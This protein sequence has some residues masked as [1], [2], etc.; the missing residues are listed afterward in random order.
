MLLCGREP[1]KGLDLL[2]RTGLLGLWL[3]ELL[4]MQGCVQNHHHAYPVWEHSLEVV[5]RAD[6]DPADRWA[7]LLHDGGKPGTRTQDA[8]GV[9]HFHGHEAVSERLAEAILTRLRAS[10]ALTATVVALVRHHGTH[11]GPGWGDPACRRFLKRL[12]EDGLALERW[13]AFRLADQS[14]KGFG[15]ERCDADHVATMA[16][17]EALAQVRP[18]L[19][20]KALALDGRALMALARRKG[21][22]WLGALQAHLM[23]QVLDEPALNQADALAGLV[24]IWLKTDEGA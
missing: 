24:R 18:P 12:G 19:S 13:G 20:V 17:L 15:G 16:R 2:A 21:G 23:E 6:L 4:P 9:N 8:N 22:P 3:P 7:A 11:P 10:N 1:G 5:R 14:G